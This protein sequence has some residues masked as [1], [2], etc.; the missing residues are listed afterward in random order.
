MGSRFPTIVIIKST[1]TKDFCT[2]MNF[3]LLIIHCNSITTSICYMR[4]QVQH[5]DMHQ[6]L[7]SRKTVKVLKHSACCNFEPVK[8]FTYFIKA[9]MCRTLLVL[10]L[11]KTGCSQLTHHISTFSMSS[12]IIL[13]SVK[14]LPYLEAA[15]Y[16]Y[17]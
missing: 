14:N 10:F 4:H 9:A 17:S 15:T 6:T 1:C 11:S 8:I 12:S 2:K 5:T 16:C 7:G 13:H 3:I